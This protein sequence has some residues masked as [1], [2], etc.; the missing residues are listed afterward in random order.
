METISARQINAKLTLH[1]G[2]EFQ[3]YSPFPTPTRYGE[4]VF[5]TGMVGYPETMTDPSYTG[6]ILVFTYPL[7][8]NY[9]VPPR[10]QWESGKIQVAGIV[11]SELAAHAQH[12]AAEQD[13]YAWCKA[14]NIPILTGV[15]TRHLTLHLRHQ[16]VVPGALSALD[17]T[18]QDFIDI[19]ASD[20]AKTVTI[21][22]PQRLGKG[23][24]RIIVIDCGIKENILRELLKF[25]LEILRVPYDYDFTHETYDGVFIS[26]GPGDPAVYQKTIGHVKQALATQK[27]VFGIC[28]GT[29]L[30]AHAIGATTY[31]LTFGHRSQNQPCLHL[32]SNRA[33]LTS[34]N[35]GFSIDEASLPADWEVTFKN[36]N[37][38]TVQGIAHRHLPQFSVQF[39]PEAAP[40]PVDTFWLFEQFYQAL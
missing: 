17:V 38:Q 40:G 16:G 34:Q 33:Y 21:D 7:I 25:P 23:D 12:Y 27:P 31:K 26:N 18:P 14:A 2:E 29:Q 10:A 13:L 15:D 22:A 37:D 28:L 30:M 20:L 1:S 3:G 8:G 4:V 9:G 24:K 35:H 32:A 5:N 36:L 19:N 11:V 39:H 6:Q